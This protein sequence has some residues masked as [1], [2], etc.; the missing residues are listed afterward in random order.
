MSCNGD[1]ENCPMKDACSSGAV[2][3]QVL[4]AVEKVRQALENV[5]DKILVLSGK[6]GVGKSTVAYLLTRRFSQDMQIGVLDLDLCGPSMP[7]L[8]NAE[9]EHLRQTATGFEPHVVDEN[10][11]LVS[12]Q[13]FLDNIDDPVIAWGAQ[14]STMVLQLLSDVDWDGNETLII[15][16]PPGTSDEHLSIV[17]FMK[18]AGVSGAVI[19]TTPEEVALTDVRRELRFC[20]RSGIKVIGVIENMSSFVC[21]ECGKES[22]IYPRSSG[23]AQKMCEDE[24]VNFLGSIPIDPTLVCGLSGKDHILSQNVKDSISS[25]CDKIIETLGSQ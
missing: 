13:F 4:D 21:P 1:C 2:P 3:K 22:T 23:G 12:S 9:H 17:S 7:F 8:F 19:V 6:G 18:D 14:K 5:K 15:D 20:R 24:K 10:I 25:I 16:T 11:T